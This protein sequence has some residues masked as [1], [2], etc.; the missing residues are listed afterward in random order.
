MMRLPRYSIAICLFLGSSFHLS[1]GETS[2]EVKQILILYEG[3]DIPSNYGRGDARELAALLGHFHADYR[4]K[5]VDSYVPGEMKKYDVTFF[6]GFTRH[7]DPPERFLRDAASAQKQLVWLNTGIDK[8]SKFLN[9]DRQLG[10]HFV[11]FDTSYHFDAVKTK[12]WVFTK[13]DPN[14]N[15]TALARG[16]RAEVLATATSST[17][18][19]EFPYIIRSGNFLYIADSPFAAATETDRYILFADMLHEILS[20]PHE[21]I[22]RALL[23]IEDVGVFEK[24]ARLRDIADALADR[25][26]PF[27]VGIIPFYVDKASN[28]TRVSLSEKPELVD[29][30]RYMVSRGATVVLHGVT[31]QYQGATATDYEF[32]DES[33]GKTIRN[34]SKEYVEKRLKMGLEECWKNNIYPLIWETPHY[35]ASQV[36][37]RAI[38]T[39]FSTAMEQRL[40]FDNLEYSQYFPYI[41]EHDLYGQKIL[42]E[43]LGYIPLDSNR[44]AE[45]SA[46]DDLLKNAK[47]QLAVRDGFASAFIHP[48]IDLRYIEEYVDGV[49]D[50]GY[51][52]MDAKTE[53]SIVRLK[54]RVILTGAQTFQVTLEDQYLR[55]TWLDAG[56][57]I[58]RRAI[59]QER[60]NGTIT[61]TVD[62]PPGEIYLAEPSEV[63]EEKISFFERIRN[64]ARSFV[65]GIF[66]KEEG[67]DEARV[68]VRWDPGAKG[69]AMDDQASFASAFRSLNVPVDTLSADTVLDFEAYNLLVVPYPTVENLSDSEYDRITDF[70]EQ[71][72]SLITDGANPLAEE[73]GIKFAKSSI[74]IERMR[75]GLFPEES[76]T[77]SNHPEIMSRFEV[78]PSD[79]VLCNDERTDAPVVIGR[80][81]GK[82]KILFLGI[83]F[84]PVSNGGFSRFP[85][86]ME[87]VRNYLRLQPVLKRENLEFYFDPG[88]RRTIS[89]EDLVKR[90]TASGIRI[91]HAASWHE[92]PTWTYDYR[93][94]IDLCHANGILVYAWLEPPQVSQKFWKDHPEWQ[95]TNYR[96]ARVQP[97]WRFPVA[98]TSAECL[99]AVKAKF[100]DL[101]RSYDWDGVNLSELY[102]EAG[103]GP[104]D[105]R[106]MTPMHISARDA[107]RRRNGFD[108]V[109]LYDSLSLYYW[110]GNPEAWKLFEDYRV[111]TI[112][113]LH[114]E[115]LQMITEVRAS[116]PYMDVIVTA[117]DNLGAPELRRNH[118]VDISRIMALRARYHFTLQVEDPQTAWSGDPRRYLALARRYQALSGKDS[119]VMVDLN[120]GPFR[121]EKLPAPN[122]PTLIQTGIESYHLVQSSALGSDRF[123]IY[124]ESSIRPQD[125]HM[126]AYAASSPATLERREGGWKLNSP[127]PVTLELPKQYSYLTLDSGERLDPVDGSFFLPAGEHLI[128]AGTQ[129]AGPFEAPSLKGRLLS[130]TGDLESITSS[131]R[132]VTFTYRSATRCLA[133]F[134]HRPY[135]IFIDGKE[136]PP[137]A[138]RGS[139]RFSVILPYGTHTVIAVLETTVSYGVDITSLWSSWLIVI[140]GF[141]SGAALVTFY[142]TI[143]VSRRSRARS[144]SD[145]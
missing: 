58:D 119:P 72:G 98:L 53:P 50:L 20:E 103:N 107:F 29:A 7:C 138:R 19:K 131:S 74:K 16:S 145:A 117:M 100:R 108:P 80:A 14:L 49:L 42:P 96:G 41:I 46:V 76:F 61:R 102:F 84:D 77:L 43:N 92:Y 52:F 35:A 87:Y 15:L 91:I 85:Y 60:V 59:S 144:R 89:A 88:Y 64:E 33:T 10:F 143:R 94:L 128:D 73:F 78:L 134:S 141:F 123:T 70:V 28:I 8:L 137:D 38:A 12:K 136:T 118:G 21:E 47:A 81:R 106:L 124:S 25:H 23:R 111:E 104:E 9:T 27:L 22:H 99:K 2:S 97:S 67:F 142:V 34:D 105:A 40:A 57:E 31:H 32:W 86:L 122:F 90:W 93:R 110:K 112:T 18:R 120:I 66:R 36:D 139:R 82:G 75:D 39:F 71:G 45:Q 54:D 113:H 48:F 115:F 1:F 109:Q 129:G 5:A 44:A 65:N 11:S 130:I 69:S 127:F 17:R 126:I 24:P 83:R 37:Y 68:A 116:R 114:E 95:E 101:L 125:L 26:I 51:T 140:F 4:I 135:T 63:R 30:I 56:G 133:S 13:G 3:S 55:E 121:D 62:V 79:E 6:I 132:S